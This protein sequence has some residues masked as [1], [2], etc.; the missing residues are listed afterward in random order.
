MDDERFIREAV[1]LAIAAGKKGNNSFGAVLVHAG[2][3]IARAENTEVTGTSYG[4]AEYNLVMESV[5]QFPDEVL[6]ASTLYTSTAP[7]RRCSFAI[8]AAGIKEVAFSV[9]YEGFARL[10]PAEVEMLTIQEIVDKLGLE[11]L[12]IRGPFL[13]D[14]GMRAFEYWG[15]ERRSLEELL[16]AAQQQRETGSR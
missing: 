10:I 2:E 15:G 3:V 14:E 11:E 13:E 7:C 16:A 5:R 4:H 12:Q 8:L 1:E 9:S 6:R